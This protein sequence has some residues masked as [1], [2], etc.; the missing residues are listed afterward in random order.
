MFEVQLKNGKVFS[1]DSETNILAASEQAGLILEHSCLNARCRSC[2]V[3]VL[4]GE[5]V[6]E[7]EEFVL[8]KDEIKDGFVLSCNAKPISNIKLDIEDLG[9]VNFHKSTVLPAK[10]DVIETIGADILRLILRLPPSSKFKFLPGQYVNIIKGDIKRSYSIANIPRK[11]KKIE[12][13][14]RKH[15]RG[16]MSDYFF[17]KAKINDLLRLEG[18]LGTFFYRKNDSIKDIIFLATGTGIAPVKAIL[19]EFNEDPEYLNDKNIWLF[20]GGRYQKDIFFNPEFNLKNFIFTPV[21]SRENEDWQGE[22][23]YVQD[24]LLRQEIDFENAV[25]YACGS[26]NMILSA[27]ILLIKNNLKENNFY[28]DAFVSSN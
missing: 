8:S 13:Y 10:I 28:S 21:L 5:V 25:V 17:S 22:K 11:D 1:C 4:E 12:F 9:D 16:L 18:P 15:N 20:W 27:K 19:E 3:K 6:N 14:I 2:K 24:I 26:N 23:G 7:Q